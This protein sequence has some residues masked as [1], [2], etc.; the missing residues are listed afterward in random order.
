[1]AP[2]RKSQQSEKASKQAKADKTAKQVMPEPATTVDQAMAGPSAA[3]A[4]RRQLGRRNTDEAVDRCL[5]EK[6]GLFRHGQTDVNKVEGKTLRE[7]LKAAHAAKRGSSQRLGCNYLRDL[8]AKFSDE[9]ISIA[10]LPHFHHLPVPCVAVTEGVKQAVLANPAKRSSDTLIAWRDYTM[11]ITAREIAGILRAVVANS[12]L[13]KKETDHVVVAPARSGWRLSVIQAHVG[14]WRA[15]ALWQPL[16]WLAASRGSRS[17]RSALG[18]SWSP[19]SSS[20]ISWWIHPLSAQKKSQSVSCSVSCSVHGAGHSMIVWCCYEAPT[21][22]SGV[23]H[24]QHILG[25]V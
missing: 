12:V 4:P 20:S 2:K 24:V 8:E 9:G 21:L 13:G 16:S 5:A 10:S 1:M 18:S 15:C 19:I 7:T 11:S 23:T 14:L 17:A 25:A 6:F 22:C 3:K